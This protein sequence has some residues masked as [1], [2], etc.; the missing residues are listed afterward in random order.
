M[1]IVAFLF[2]LLFMLPAQ[3]ANNTVLNSLLAPKQ[4]T[5]LP[6]NEAFQFDF[7]QQG[8]ILFTGWEIAPGYYIYKHKLEIIA[9]NAKIKVPELDPG[10]EIEDEFFGK[11]EVY[12]DELVVVSR[13][14]DI[15][16]DAVVK[17]RYQG[18][19]EAGLCYPPEVITIPLSMLNKVSDKPNKA[20]ETDAPA[21]NNSNDFVNKL[22]EQDFLTN[23]A[24]FFG[25][26]VL[27]AFTPCVF[28]M[29]PILSS[30][31][32]G[33][34][35]LST[36]KAFALSFVYVQGMAV[37]YAAL[38]LVV[39]AVGGQIQGYLQSPAVLISFSL[40]FVLLAFAMFGWYEIKLPEKF[41][42]RLT[43]VSNQQKGG[44]YTG[45]FFMGV[46]SGL[47]ASPCTTAPLSAAL[48]YV[49]QSGDYLVGGLTLYVLSL[50]MGLPLLL[51]G[52]S[53]GKLLPKAGAWMEQVKMLFGF[54]ML[55]VPLVLLE[56]I[57]DW[58]TILLLSSVWLIITALFLHHWQSQEQASKLKTTLWAAAVLF[59]IGGVLTAKHVL[60]PPAKVTAV[61]T[62]SD[63]KFKLLPD[64][65]ALREEVAQA[66]QQGKIAMVDLYADW[67][68]ACKEFEKYTFS[69]NKVKQA[70]KDFSLLKLDLT[71]TNEVSKE[72]YQ[73][74]NVVG[75]PA[76][77]FFDAQG[78]ELSNLR[79]TGFQSAEEFTAH[80]EKVRQTV[81]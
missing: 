16:E 63:G 34:S 28:P 37:T 62:A 7:D 72:I 31:I 45:V 9:K 1:R 64:L 30:L 42:T 23:L 81:Q 73:T 77:L 58:N 18:C 6:V 76:I 56:R 39:A 48:L 27:L 50:G 69:D 2:C 75:L 20:A 52:T 55:V 61:A 70:F 13:L 59:M 5:F 17:I 54:V 21:G 53:G 43:N 29:F 49:A 25:V 24:V 41:M 40:L 11:T 35:K 8:T 10:V 66:N 12:F 46:L 44:N 65:A 79:I 68:V 47:I 60:M 15:S 51:L 32:A 19:A 78:N 80:L 33:Q 14:S 57:L 71:V 74:F 36:K 38:G 4:Q 3:A 67:C 26:G 22:A